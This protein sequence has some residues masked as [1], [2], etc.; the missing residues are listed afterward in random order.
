MTLASI[1]RIADQ[2]LAKEPVLVF[3]AFEKGRIQ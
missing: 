3:N 1:C 2:G